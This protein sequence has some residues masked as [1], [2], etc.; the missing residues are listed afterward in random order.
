MELV[1]VVAAVLATF[2]PPPLRYWGCLHSVPLCVPTVNRRK[3][4]WTEVFHLERWFCFRK[5]ESII[6]IIA[7]ACEI[8]AVNPGFTLKPFWSV[9]VFARVRPVAGSDET[10][11]KALES[12]DKNFTNQKGVD[13]K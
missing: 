7:G 11:W 6:I 5:K 1:E 9:S 3:P 13:S 4:A 2:T 8:R 12:K 10:T